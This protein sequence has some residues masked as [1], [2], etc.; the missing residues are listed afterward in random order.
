M[1]ELALYPS[2]TFK[3]RYWKENTMCTHLVHSTPEAVD[4]ILLVPV[5]FPQRALRSKSVHTSNVQLWH[6]GL[7]SHGAVISDIQ[8]VFWYVHGKLHKLTGPA[9]LHT[10]TNITWYKGG[11]SHR[12]DGCQHHDFNVWCTNGCIV[13][14]S[15]ARW[16]G[17]RRIVVGFVPREPFNMSPSILS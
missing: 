16:E 7:R 17:L 12:T 3:Y 4:N 11:W 2:F 6:I 5:K 15:V 9:L 8:A 10:K 14:R 1:H 13:K